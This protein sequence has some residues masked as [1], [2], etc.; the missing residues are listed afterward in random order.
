MIHRLRDSYF[1]RAPFWR[2]VEVIRSRGGKRRLQENQRENFRQVMEPKMINKRPCTCQTRFPRLE[3]REKNLQGSRPRGLGMGNGASR[4]R[5]PTYHVALG[6]EEAAA[7]E[8]AWDCDRLAAEGTVSPGSRGRRPTAA[9]ETDSALNG[10]G[11]PD[12]FQMLVRLCGPPRQDATDPAGGL[13]CRPQLAWWA[14]VGIT[15]LRNVINNCS[16]YI[17]S[18]EVPS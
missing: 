8:I 10:G 15:T 5:S 11:I 7:E 9:R 1:L 12:A 4:V 17:D 13:V 3:K 14:E 18:R 6:T 2:V 16:D